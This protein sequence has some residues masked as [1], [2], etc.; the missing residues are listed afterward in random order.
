VLQEWFYK[1]IGKITPEVIEK[2]FVYNEKEPL[3]FNT[4]LFLG[5]FLVFYFWYILLR[6]ADTMRMVYV[7]LFSLFFYYKSSGVYF[8]LLLGS[9]VVDYNLGNLVHRTSSVVNKRLCL[10]FSIILNLGFLG[11]FKYSKFA[12]EIFNDF[13]DS[14]LTL[15][16]IILPV[17]ISFYTFQSI[18]YLI[19]VYRKEIEPT[20]RFIDYLFCV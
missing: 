17:G 13:N 9:A 19:E 11:Y 16:K 14:N 15:G 6:K 2:W 4:G 7:I 3:L 18:S 8:L 10:A 1:N 20:R 5:L 12:L